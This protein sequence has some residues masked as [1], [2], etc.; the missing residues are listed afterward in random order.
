MK[1]KDIQIDIIRGL[2]IILVVLGHSHCPGTYYIYLFH[3]ALFFILGGYCYKTNH[4]DTFKNFLKF[5]YKKIIR[6]YVPF[7]VLN[8]ILVLIDQFIFNRGMDTK[9]LFITI[10]N[11]FILNQGSTLSGAFWFLKIMLLLL[12]TYGLID[13][14]LKRI[15]DSKKKT[16]IAHS[17][18]SVIFLSIGYICSRKGLILWGFDKVMSY[19]ILFHMGRIF[20]E[21]AYP[22][23]SHAKR[24]IIMTASLA[25]LIICRRFGNIDLDINQYVNPLFLLITSISGWLLIYEMAY[26]IFF[27]N[28]FNI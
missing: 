9:W 19:Y 20:N 17:I 8:T 13:Y 4:T 28:G 2:G 18:L 23:I 16:M 15:W 1:T 25:T 21:Q 26:L 12:L 5:S 10:A 3:M 24:I 14:L 6:L 22:V 11:G 7:V 27:I